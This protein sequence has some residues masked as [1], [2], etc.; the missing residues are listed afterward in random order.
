MNDIDNDYIELQ[1][2]NNS[3]DTEE[4]VLENI[5]PFPLL[6]E[7]CEYNL[8]IC[9][10]SVDTSE[11]PTFIP[12]IEPPSKSIF[13][14]ENNN[15]YPHRVV[16]G[17]LPN[18]EIFSQSYIDS[19]T[20]QIKFNTNLEIGFEVPSSTGYDSWDST[21]NHWQDRNY[22]GWQGKR[23][24]WIPE[25][26]FD[27]PPANIIRSEVLKS[28]YFYC[29]SVEHIYN[30]IVKQL[31]F[32]LHSFPCS[33]IQNIMNSGGGE[34]ELSV[35]DK[36]ACLFIPWALCQNSLFQQC[37]IILNTDLDNM[38]GFRT[39][40]H[41]TNKNWR[42]LVIQYEILQPIMMGV[43]NLKYATIM[44][45][46]VSSDVFPFS[47]IGFSSTSL[48]TK[49]MLVHNNNIIG[50]NNSSIPVITD[51]LLDVTDLDQ[52]Y[53]TLSYIPDAYSRKIKLLNTNFQNIVRIKLYLQTSDG[54]YVPINIRPRGKAS[55]LIQFSKIIA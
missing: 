29:Y 43:N 10:F 49:K 26:I 53:N 11:I 37:R 41:E 55:I 33:T 40:P 14:D 36:R 15:I 27:I 25:N 52:F 28:K 21:S 16:N 46:Y 8:T 47:R 9:R 23:I 18:E 19:V 50:A 31:N 38:F 34:I 51:L 20:G 3:G 24:V 39:I 6:Q 1:Y 42:I 22:T 44:E 7:D 35:V 45:G 4:C 54:Y 48:Q 12:R 17:S 32:I 2:F 5:R 30:L 13:F